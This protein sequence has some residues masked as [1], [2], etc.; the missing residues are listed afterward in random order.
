MA[1]AAGGAEMRED[2]RRHP[3]CLTDPSD[4]DLLMKLY[5]LLGLDEDPDGARSVDMRAAKGLMERKPHLLMACYLDI[6]VVAEDVRPMYGP[7]LTPLLVQLLQSPDVSF[8]DYMGMLKLTE[9]LWPI[10]ESYVHM[11]KNYKRGDDS[12]RSP[13]LFLF[14]EEEHKDNGLTALAAHKLCGLFE[15]LRVRSEKK[16]KIF[17]FVDS[18]LRNIALFAA[19]KFRLSS[20]LCFLL[21]CDNCKESSDKDVLRVSVLR[22]AIAS[23]LAKREEAPQAGRGRARPLALQRLGLADL[24]VRDIRA[25]FKYA[26]DRRQKQVDSQPSLTLDIDAVLEKVCDSVYPQGRVLWFCIWYAKKLTVGYNVEGTERLIDAF[27]KCH[28]EDQPHPVFASLMPRFRVE[29]AEERQFA[30][31]D[32]FAGNDRLQ[33]ELAVDARRA[34]RAQDE[35]EE[36]D[37]DEEAR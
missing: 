30:A 22:V 35:Y 3:A 6:S 28:A 7:I 34:A 37:S 11:R 26:L 2:W 29:L 21:F 31:D 23:P 25:R 8:L 18:K 17:S 36:D 20:L 5:V 4:W 10:W 16:V 9:G 14:V 19:Q 32:F 33:A 12:Y 27:L 1:A 15:F 13:Y 24:L